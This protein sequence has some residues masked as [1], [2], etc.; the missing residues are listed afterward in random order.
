MINVNESGTLKNIS[1]ESDGVV[2]N[3]KLEILQPLEIYKPAERTDITNGIFYCQKPVREYSFV[4]VYGFENANPHMTTLNPQSIRL[5]AVPV[6][7]WDYNNTGVNGGIK[8]GVELTYS[9]CADTP[10]PMSYSKLHLYIAKNLLTDNRIWYTIDYGANSN[11]DGIFFLAL[12]YF[13]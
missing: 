4:V 13:E 9:I 10:N 5:L 7:A 6:L 11:M 1:T 2:K 3:M 12:V 8:D